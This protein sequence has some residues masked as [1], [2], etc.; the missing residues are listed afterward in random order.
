[1]PVS[2]VEVAGL[3]SHYHIGQFACRIYIYGIM[4]NK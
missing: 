3:I 4:V 1:M 2:F